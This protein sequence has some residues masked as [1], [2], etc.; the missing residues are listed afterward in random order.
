MN[1]DR[2]R[3]LVLLTYRDIEVPADHPLMDV[4][5]DLD[6]IRPLERLRL[7]GLSTGE[8]AEL[9][10]RTE[11]CAYLR[12]AARAARLYD[13]LAPY[14]ERHV[15][16]SFAAHLGSVHRYLGLLATTMSAWTRTEEHF[17]AAL[18]RHADSPP[19][20]IRTLC[21]YAQMLESAGR[22][23]DAE[24]AADLQLQLSL[25]Q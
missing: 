10:G 18:R 23:G 8:S 17:E 20:T 2:S 9:I 3:L 1:P 15:Q 6:R 22:S 21:D 4:L 19:L 11:G 13:L 14:A 24:R 7:G 25:R 16:L 12:D 5:A